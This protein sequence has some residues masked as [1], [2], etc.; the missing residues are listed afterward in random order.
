MGLVSY[1]NKLVFALDKI[2]LLVVY[3][4]CFTQY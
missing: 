4:Y 1:L 3:D 2:L